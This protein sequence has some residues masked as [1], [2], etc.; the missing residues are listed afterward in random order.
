[1]NRGDTLYLLE[2]YI[3]EY[4]NECSDLIEKQLEKEFFN[5]E[6]YTYNY[7]HN[8]RKI[9]DE[10]W[11]QLIEFCKKNRRRKWKINTRCLKTL[12]IMNWRLPK[13]IFNF[14]LKKV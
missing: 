3:F 14:G 5:E 11:N 6:L 12:C 10:K 1:M 2:Q 7:L 13:K 8:Q 4:K 9:I